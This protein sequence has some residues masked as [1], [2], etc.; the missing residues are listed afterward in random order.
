MSFCAEINP[1]DGA[2]RC[3]IEQPAPAIKGCTNLHGCTGVGNHICDGSVPHMLNHL[4]VW[5]PVC[6]TNMSSLRGLTETV[7]SRVQCSRAADYLSL[8]WRN[9]Q[10]GVT[11]WGAELGFCVPVWGERIET[12]IWWM[13]GRDCK[14]KI[15]LKN[16]QVRLHLWKIISASGK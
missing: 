3:L 15:E 1:A 12:A 5:L 10:W 7:G 13:R 4:S 8:R 11:E 9:Y 16:R 6:H 14:T 2:D